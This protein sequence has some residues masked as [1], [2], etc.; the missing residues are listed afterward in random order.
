LSR[1]EAAGGVLWRHG[2]DGRVEVCLVHRP[3]YDDWT[4]PKG[5][6]TV[7]EHPLVGAVRE[8]LEETG[9]QSRPGRPLGQLRY[10]HEG[11]PKRV[12]YWALQLVSAGDFT[13]GAEIDELRWLALSEAASGLRPGFDAGILEAF[14]ADPRPTWPV[15]LIRHARAGSRSDWEGPDEERPLDQQGQR[16]AADL[17]PVLAAFGVRNLVSAGVARCLQTLAPY[18]AAAGGLPT[19]HE[20]AFSES[21][22]AASPAK[23]VR[24]L[25]ALCAEGGATAV[26]SQGKA[27]PGLLEGA[28]LRMKL[29]PP[30]NRTTPKGGFWALHVS[31]GPELVAMERFDPTAAS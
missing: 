10:L 1:I 13:P 24:R 15:L 31:H 11:K 9:C 4:L 18:A 19:V 3:K 30:V 21:G 23:S 29:D 25:V 7:G 20:P 27:M 22:F 17:V 12:R 16:Q 8:A 14:A 2:A 5:K 28:T 26:C 6:L